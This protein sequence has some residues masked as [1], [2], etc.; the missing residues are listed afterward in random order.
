VQLQRVESGDD[1]V[2]PAVQQAGRPPVVARRRAVVQQHDAGHQRLPWSARPTPVG[3]RRA[4]QTDRLQLADPN[5]GGVTQGGVLLGSQRVRSARHIVQRAP[6]DDESGED[7]EAC[8]W[9]GRIV[10]NRRSTPG[11]PTNGTLVG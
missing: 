6:D 2:R 10:D 5:H 9:T 3:G 1:R 11:F 8:G 7:H 4:V